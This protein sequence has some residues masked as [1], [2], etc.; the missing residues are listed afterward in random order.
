MK[1]LGS[2]E[3]NVSSLEVRVDEDESGGRYRQQIVIECD[4]STICAAMVSKGEL[5]VSGI[6]GIECL[7]NIITP[8]PSLSMRSL[9]RGGN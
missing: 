5:I 4:E 3:I 6:K 7:M 2:W 9:R 1:G 8:P